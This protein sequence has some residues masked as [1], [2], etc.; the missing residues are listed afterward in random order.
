[1]NALTICVWV[2]LSLPF[3]QQVGDQ[4]PAGYIPAGCVLH[5]WSLSTGESLILESSKIGHLPVKI[6]KPIQVTK[7][8]SD[9]LQTLLQSSGLFLKPI[10]RSSTHWVTMDP[11]KMP[12]RPTQIIRV[13]P[14]QHLDCDSICDLLRQ[15][16]KRREKNLEPLDRYSNFVSDLR[17]NS[18]VI[19]VASEP[20]LKYY[21]NFIAKTDQ[22]PELGNDRPV[23][24]SWRAQKMRSS[25]LAELLKDRWS[26]RGGQPIQV[27]A[28]EST[29]TLLIR[30]PLHLWAEAEKILQQLDG[31]SDS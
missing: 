26:D 3:P 25:Q 21:L 14:I 9:F 30:I 8:A 1:M 27:V 7:S 20:R 10:T 29:N 6:L 5:A 18:V 17:S 16:A 22:P 15:E 28:N 11:L 4:L 12:P 24:R 23:L 19:T 2:G 13:I 31:H